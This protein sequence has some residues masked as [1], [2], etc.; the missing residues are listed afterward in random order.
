MLSIIVAYDCFSSR[1]Q[2]ERVGRGVCLGT[3]CLLSVFQAITISPTGS[4]WAELKL[5]APQYIRPLSILCWILSLLRFNHHYD[6]SHRRECVNPR[7]RPC[8]HRTY[9]MART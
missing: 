8:P 7:P 1:S 3:T 9:H 4:R 6:H 5:Q 2:R